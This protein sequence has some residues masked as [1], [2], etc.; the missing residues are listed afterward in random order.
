MLI[1][2]CSLRRRRHPPPPF[3]SIP[4]PNQCCRWSTN[5]SY[6]TSWSPSAAAGVE[7]AVIILGRNGKVIE[8]LVTAKRP[9]NLKYEFVY[10]PEP[11]G[12]AHAVLLAGE[13]LQ[14]GPFLMYLG[15]NLSPSP[16]AA[17]RTV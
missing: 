8:D 7:K 16:W 11:L 5:R 17:N 9:G 12:L 1:K 13:A 2:L 4:N 15:D 14:Y 6:F 10:Q 3:Y